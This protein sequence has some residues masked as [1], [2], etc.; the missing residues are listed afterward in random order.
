MVVCWVARGLSHS[1]LFDCVHP[2]GCL[3]RDDE[4]TFVGGSGLERLLPGIV[5]EF[6]GELVSVVSAF[7]RRHGALCFALGR[8]ARMSN[9]TAKTRCNVS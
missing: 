6:R 8:C 2:L 3:S 5:A 7:S 9:S 1:G 4:I